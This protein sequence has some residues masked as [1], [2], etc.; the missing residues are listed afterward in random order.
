MAAN[1]PNSQ[2]RLISFVYGRGDNIKY[3]MVEEITCNY[4]GILILLEDSMSKS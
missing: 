2:L 1:L 3:E 4:D